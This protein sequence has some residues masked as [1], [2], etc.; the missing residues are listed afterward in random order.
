MIVCT[1]GRI[2]V[3]P[4]KDD[5]KPTQRSVSTSGPR[6]PAGTPTPKGSERLLGTSFSYQL[7]VRAQQ[8]DREAIEALCAR[9]LPRLKAWGTGRLPREARALLET[10]DIVGDVLTKAIE[11]IDRIELRGEGALLA[12]LRQALLNRIRDE[13]R[14]V[15]RRPVAKSLDEDFPETDL[16]PLEESMG[17]G[18]I[19]SYE[20]ALAKLRDDEQ[21][22][23]I[24][25]IEMSYSYQEIA[26][27]LGRPSA[28]A[29]RMAVSRALVRLVREMNDVRA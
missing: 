26:D 7:A 5:R 25:R 14:K 17:R 16:S 1:S 28:D 6:R 23:I 22:L 24:A 18:P 12:Y 20:A 8:G 29:A 27:A 13:V 4:V 10:D 15:M 21:Q 11:R 19:A 2:E 3:P 9:Y